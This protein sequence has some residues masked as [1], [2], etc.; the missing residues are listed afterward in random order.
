MVAIVLLA[1]AGC[2]T[3][4]TYRTRTTVQRPA[5]PGSYHIVRR[6]ETLWRIARSYGLDVDV[7]AAAN[8]LTNTNRIGTGQKLFIPL[9]TE[10]RKFLWPVRGPI[11]S[12]GP[13]GVEISAPA[14]SLIRAARSGEVAVAT[15]HLSGWG[16]TVIL[17]HADGYLSIYAGL[18]EFLVRPGDSVRQGLPLGRLGAHALHFEI[19]YGSKS[20][21]TLALLPP[22]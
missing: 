4:P 3:V 2:E 13:N 12:P 9:P 21:N 17:D 6:G 19:R 16:K 22:R 7:L 15:R 14:G 11:D 20:K 1:L 5:L 10:S 8:R 18:E